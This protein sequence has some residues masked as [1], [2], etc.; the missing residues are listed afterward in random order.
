VRTVFRAHNLH[1]IGQLMAPNLCG[2]ARKIKFEGGTVD[3][4]RFAL[5]ARTEGAT[6]GLE[7]TRNS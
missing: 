5:E 2:W 4:S 7:S 1:P 6:W 3:L